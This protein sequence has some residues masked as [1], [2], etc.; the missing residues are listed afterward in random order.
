MIQGVLLLSFVIAFVITLVVHKS[1]L[2][3][4]SI[5]SCDV[6]T[7]QYFQIIGINEEL[8]KTAQST[9]VSL[10]FPLSTS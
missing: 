4:A 1:S 10:F 8:L 2:V 3:D 5:F 7:L 6:L 9:S